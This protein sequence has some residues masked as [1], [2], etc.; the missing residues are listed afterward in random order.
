MAVT[1][2]RIEV[3]DAELDDL[4]AA[5]ARTRWPSEVDDAG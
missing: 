4:H 2:F 1:P 3:P 5:I